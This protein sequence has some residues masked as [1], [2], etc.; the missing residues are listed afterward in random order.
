M[1]DT[2]RVTPKAR[3]RPFLKWAG[4]KGRLL[5]QFE[6]LLPDKI[7]DYHEP[8]LG[9]GA[10]FF[11]LRERISGRAYLSD[12]IEDLVS[13]FGT[14]RDNV[15]GLIRHLGRH[16]YESEHYYRVR[17]QNPARL[18]PASLAAR[19]IYLNRT[20]FNGLYRVN[21]S[22]RFNVPFGRYTNPTICNA[23]GLRAASAALAGADLARRGFAELPDWVEPGD[24]VYLDPP[25]QPLSKTASFTAYTAG[26]FGENEQRHLAEICRGLDKLGA[27]FMLSNSDTPLIRE[28]YKGFDIQKVLAARAIN[29]TASKRGKVS[30]VV[31]R[32]YT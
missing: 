1:S 27:R 28:I 4:G 19:F 5:A 30:E 14:V 24:F 25:Y 26:G 16:V 21:K 32:N 12:R 9:S 11:H 3:V 31:V 20:G 23:P 17:A 7:E 29:A 22:G 13:T 8:F 10:V 6:P 2:A 15:E 18:S